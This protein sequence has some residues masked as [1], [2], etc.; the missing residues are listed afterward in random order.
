[1]ADAHDARTAGAERGDA[2]LT[3]EEARTVVAR[4][5]TRL[6]RVR[7]NWFNEIDDARLDLSD[8]RAC[9]VGQLTGDYY[10]G[11]EQLG[12][13]E[14]NGPDY[15]VALNPAPGPLEPQWRPLQDAWIEAIADRR[16]PQ[17]HDQPDS[18]PAVTVGQP[19]HPE[20]AIRA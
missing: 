8:C 13:T 2:M 5:A 3:Q 12:F 7:P 18:A 1:M 11:R 15:G 16:F 9:I 20:F 10:R 14:S 6:D 4:G 19:D 17:R